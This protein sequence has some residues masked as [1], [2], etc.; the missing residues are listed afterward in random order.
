[1]YKPVNEEKF[2]QMKEFFSKA[3]TQEQLNA[4]AL[5]FIFDLSYHREDITGA[6]HDV[7]IE[8]GWR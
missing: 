3:E 5:L 6:L 2:K 7:E 4:T 1:M 8:K